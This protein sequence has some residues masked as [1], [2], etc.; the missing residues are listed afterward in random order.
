MENTE[1]LLQ[2]KEKIE[3]EKNNLVQLRTEKRIL[4]ERLKEEFGLESVEG[5]EKRLIRVR[6]QIV[7]LEKNFREKLDEL[8]RKYP[9][10]A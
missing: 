3:K 1:I 5:A 9:I 6:R 2:Y 10:V 8:Q 4:E 7:T